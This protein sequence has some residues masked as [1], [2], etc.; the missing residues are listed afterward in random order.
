MKDF[1]G[2][3]I[4]TDEYGELIELP[5]LLDTN[6][7]PYKYLKAFNPESQEFVWL[8]TWPEVK[9]PAEAE[10]RSYRL[11]RFGKTYKPISRT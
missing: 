9:T 10:A 3:V 6:N 5:K 7:V 2:K 11:E 1:D 4:A 8:R